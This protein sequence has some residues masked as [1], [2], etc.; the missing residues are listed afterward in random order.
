MLLIILLFIIVFVIFIA[1]SKK[2]KQFREENRDFYNFFLTLSA[3]FMGV[4]L[5][6]Y[7]TGISAENQEEKEVIQLLEAA[8]SNAKLTFDYIEMVEGILVKYNSKGQSE[9]YGLI[10]I[11]Q[12][13]EPNNG[14]PYPTVFEKIVDDNRVLKHLSGRG[15]NV[16][17]DAQ[18]D[19]EKQEFAITNPRSSFDQKIDSLAEYKKQVKYIYQILGI[20]IKYLKDDLDESELS[21]LYT[22]NGIEL[23]GITKEE[24]EIIIKKYLSER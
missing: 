11:D 10:Q 2:M 15:L 8:E 7:L 3:T 20:E 21:S 18:K 9:K 5:A 12:L 6:I 14:I 17:Y 1:F 22:S 13:F 24:Y 4:V 23:I 19:L 16:F